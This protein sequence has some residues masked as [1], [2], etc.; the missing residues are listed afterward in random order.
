[1]G[2]KI[3]IVDDEPHIVELVKYNLLQEGYDVVTAS[4]G[5]EAVT[6]ARDAHPDL[7]ILDLMLPY[8]DGLE[9]C[10]KIRRES[11]VPIL[12]LTAKDGE[13]A[14]VVGLE[15]GADDYVT[16]PFSPRELTAR[17]RAI[18]RRT[19]REAAPS[20]PGPLHGGRLTLNPE[21]HDVT[22]DGRPV[23]L[24]AK[25]FELLHLVMSHPNR[26]FT[27]DFLLEHIWGYDYYGSTRT[28]DMH[29]SRLREKIEDDPAAPMHIVTVRGVGYKFRADAALRDVERRQA[30][31]ATNR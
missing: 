1:M 26:V 24:T 27:R 18:L 30:T 10:R 22:L 17:V 12:M 6:R 13:L 16:K 11:S 3:L 7:I 21:T 19:A 20:I 31:N 4:D 8:I 28:V 29:I 14:R 2:Q 5:S 23:D 25:E 15:I 9:V